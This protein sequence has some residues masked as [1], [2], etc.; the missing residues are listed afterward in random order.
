MS[1]LIENLSK[2][3]KNGTTA[4]DGINLS[5]Q[6]GLFGLLGPNGAGK[7]TL[8][9]TLA[10]LQS[11]DTGTITMGDIDVLTQAMAVRRKLGYLPQDFGVYPGVSAEELLN[12]FALLKGLTDPKQR[13]KCVHHLLNLVNLYEERKKAVSQFSGGMRQRFGVAQAL[14]SD[15]YLLIVDEPTAGLDPMERSRLNALLN[16]I[17]QDRL[18][19]LSTHIVSD[20]WDL[21]PDMA[22]L[23]KGKVA[24]KGAPSAAV[25]ALKNKVWESEVKSGSSP[26]EYQGLLLSNRLRQGRTVMRVYNEQCPGDSFLGVEPDLQDAYFKALKEA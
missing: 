23:N 6:P 18:V 7:S 14:I 1:L 26:I 12:Y 25:T 5:I 21:C 20:V 11:P 2:K 10:T 24:F 13:R 15:P 16:E 19:I 17:S 22:I 9:R 4:L 8:M 3:Y